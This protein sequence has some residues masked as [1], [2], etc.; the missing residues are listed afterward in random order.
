MKLNYVIKYVADMDKSVEFFR[1]R[2]GLA[3]K[4]QTP[5]WTEFAT[6]E[7]TLALHSASDEHP[8]GS[9]SIGFH[10]DDIDGFYSEA[11]TGGVQ[12]TSAPTD[13]FGQRIARFQDAD[14]A[15][16]GVSGK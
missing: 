16:C 11:Q 2:L 3:L 15:E 13:L 9:A 6:G 8:A 10:V 12:F 5:D 4:F 14:G 1:D 7:T